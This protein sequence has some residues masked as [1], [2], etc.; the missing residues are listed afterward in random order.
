MS[1]REEWEV[2]AQHVATDGCYLCAS[3]DENPETFFATKDGSILSFG[4]WMDL[5]DP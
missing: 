3:D 1:S 4:Q 5:H 2:G